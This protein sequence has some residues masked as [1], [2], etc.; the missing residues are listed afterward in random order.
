[1]CIS[2]FFHAVGLLVFFIAWPN[3]D[4]LYFIPQSVFDLSFQIVC[5][6]IRNTHLKCLK[7]PCIFSVL[8]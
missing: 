6:D 2:G 5:N 1:M 8:M 3:V 4:N 7:C